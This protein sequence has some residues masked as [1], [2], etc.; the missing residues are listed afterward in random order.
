TPEKLGANLRRQTK[1][2]VGGTYLK[3]TNGTAVGLVF[4]A[5]GKVIVALPGPPRELQTM[6]RDELVPFLSHA[7]ARACPAAR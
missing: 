3:N 5:K 1:V 4:E 6:V 2:P 7:S